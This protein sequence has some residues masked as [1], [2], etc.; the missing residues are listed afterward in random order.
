MFTTFRY[1]TVLRAYSS[2]DLICDFPKE[3]GILNMHP[4]HFS[5]FPQMENEEKWAKTW[6]TACKKLWLIFRYIYVLH[7]FRDMSE[8]QDNWKHSKFTKEWNK[9]CPEDQRGINVVVHGEILRGHPTNHCS[10]DHVITG[11]EMEKEWL[12]L[13]ISEAPQWL[14]SYGSPKHI[15]MLLSANQNHIPIEE[16]HCHHKP[17]A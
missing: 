5:L 3:P 12:L 1:S 17:G 13:A 15:C 10:H 16:S 7:H 4:E 11:V 6:H 8:Y 2:S 14:K 9:C